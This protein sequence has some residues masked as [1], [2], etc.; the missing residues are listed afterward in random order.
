[1]GIFTKVDKGSKLVFE[2]TLYVRLNLESTSNFSECKLVINSFVPNAPFLYLLKTSKT[3]VSR[4][5]TVEKL[6]LP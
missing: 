3:V 1:M 4:R 5:K 2:E 6:S